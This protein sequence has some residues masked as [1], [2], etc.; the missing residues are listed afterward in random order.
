MEEALAGA[1][2]DEESIAAAAARADE[3]IDEVN[4]DI[5][6]SEEYR[7]EMAKVFAGRAIRRA[8]GRAGE[9]A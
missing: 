3:G 4:A 8:V 2:L 7:R 9:R 5:H 6:A 1:R